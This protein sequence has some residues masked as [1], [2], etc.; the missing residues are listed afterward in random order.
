VVH[1]IGADFERVAFDMGR[2][3]C[4]SAELNG[5][6]GEELIIS[7]RIDPRNNIWADVLLRY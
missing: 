6:T 1:F 3:S 5:A 4:T 2:A 7:E